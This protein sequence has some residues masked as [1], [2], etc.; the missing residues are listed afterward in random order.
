MLWNMLF[1][2]CILGIVKFGDYIEECPQG[3]YACPNICAV[4]HEHY[5][6]K[7]CN[8]KAEQESKSD[9]TIVQSVKQ[10]HEKTVAANKSKGL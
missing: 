9:S 3:E 4:N 6:R 10:L 8:G 7:E 1:G 5:P 2:L